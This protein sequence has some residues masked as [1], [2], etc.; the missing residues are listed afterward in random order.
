MSETWRLFVAISLPEDVLALLAQYQERLRGL[1][2]GSSWDVR[3]SRTESMHLTLKFLGHVPSERAPEIEE[4]LGPLGVQ[5][6]FV[7]DVNGIGAFPR[8]SHPQVLWAGIE[9]GVRGLQAIAAD[10]GALLEP[11][12]FPREKRPFQPHITLARVKRAARGAK[13]VLDRVHATEARSFEVGEVRLY[14]SHLRREGAEHEI[15]RR[16]ALKKAG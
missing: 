3:F 6:S 8:R 12:G 13:L 2:A 10:V 16:F 1:L 5:S 9:K 11:L 15:L 7:C 4:A 14:R